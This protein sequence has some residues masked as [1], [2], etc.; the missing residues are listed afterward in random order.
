MKYELAL[1]YDDI[2]LVPRFS[3]IE[4]RQ[5]ISLK[6]KIS[7]NYSIH[8][9][10]I[11]SP[12]DTICE[13]EMV[14]KLMQYG[15]TGCIHRF[16]SIDYQVQQ[17]KE[18][19]YYQDTFIKVKQ[20]IIAAIG[21]TNDYFKR[22]QSLVKAGA[23]ILI[24]DVAHGHHEYVKRALDKL[25]SNMPKHVDIIAGNIATQESAKDLENWGADGLRVGIGG[26]SLCTTRIKTGFG[27]PNVTSIINCTEDINIPVIADGGIRSSGDIA[28]AIAVGADCVML[29]S[30]LSGTTET[31]QDKIET[32][33]G[34][35]KEYRGMAS[36]ETKMKHNT[37]IRNVEGMSTL[38]PYKGSCATILDDLLD[39]LRSA[40]SYSGS[41]NI[42]EYTAKTNFVRVTNAGIVESKPH[43]L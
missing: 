1:T 9:P 34:I 35:F 40:L 5:Y 3:N 36:A 31:P 27:I 30:L 42:P 13:S 10:I 18:V 23:E 2:Q 21:A 14:I 12:M 20:P 38:I 11:A 41:S 7:K 29:G 8:A 6:T 22:A 25:K 33:N 37:H 4:S 43:L 26:G 28:K 19:K 32:D 39:G 15:G 24:I 17:I 16:C